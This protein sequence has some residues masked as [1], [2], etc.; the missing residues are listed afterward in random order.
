MHEEWVQGMIK[1]RNKGTKLSQRKSSCES[2]RMN[3]SR[4][5]VGKGG[6]SGRNHF[7]NVGGNEEKPDH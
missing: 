4:W 1:V 3:G 5:K 6:G 7:W 2:L